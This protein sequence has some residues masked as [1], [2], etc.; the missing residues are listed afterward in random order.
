[1]EFSDN[2]P[3][4]KQIIEY[5][6]DCV[7]GG[8]WPSDG[9]IP[10]TKDLSVEL[11]VNNRTVLKAYDDLHASGIIYQKRGLGYFVSPEA[12]ELIIA[13][14]RRDFFDRVVPDVARQMRSLGIS[15]DEL[16]KAVSQPE[17]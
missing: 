3:I 15:A 13:T 14:R 8:K 11:A 4:Y 16:L 6:Y 10:S 5:C 2:L 9:R 17:K 7:L 12:C 1:M